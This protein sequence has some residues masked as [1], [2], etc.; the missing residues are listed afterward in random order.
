MLEELRR[1]L[2][3]MT[4]P[5]E[6]REEKPTDPFP[7]ISKTI[8]YLENNQ[9]RMDDPR[10]RQQGLAIMAGLVESLIKQF[11]RRVKGTEKFWN[12]TQAETILQLRAAYLCED[13]RLTKHLKKRPI[14]AF[15]SYKTTKRKKAG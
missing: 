9:P 3:A 8:G 6:S 10:Y 5:V 14:S 15:R 2:E 1:A 7:V 11:N 4:P 13:E 12:P